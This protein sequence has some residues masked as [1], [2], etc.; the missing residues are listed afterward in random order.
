[1]SVRAFALMAAAA[2]A[3]L[4]VG[5]AAGAGPARVPCGEHV[6]AAKVRCIK[7]RDSQ[8]WPRNPTMRDI[9]RR[10]TRFEL[11]ALLWICRHEQPH[12]GKRFGC[13]W[14]APYTRFVGGLGMASSTYGIGSAVTGYPYPP[15]ATAEEQL[16]VGVI[17][18]RR[19]G[20]SAWDSWGGR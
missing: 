12:S 14:D 6:G 10:L 19:F 4:G 8:A 15:Q 1:M 16:A 7:A 17:V 5:S 18:M 2:V 11:D 3:G 13:W 20:P 9:K